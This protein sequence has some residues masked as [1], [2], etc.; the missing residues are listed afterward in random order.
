MP[1]LPT[2]IFL[3]LL[4]LTSLVAAQPRHLYLTWTQ[5]DTA[6][7]QTV[8][9]QTLGQATN[10]R[11]ELQVSSAGKVKAFPVKTA[12]FRFNGRRVHWQTFSGLTPKTSYRFRA[13]DDTYGL[14][15]WRTFRT[16][17]ADDSPIRVLTGGDMYVHPATVQLL[18]AGNS[19]HPDVALVGGDIAYAEGNP[20]RFTFWDAWLDNWSR[21]MVDKQGRMVPLILAIGNHEVRGGYGR[22]AGNAPFYFGYFPQ[23]GKPYFRRKLGSEIDLVVLDSGHATA[24]QTQAPFL[25]E[26]LKKNKTRFRLALYHVPCYPTHRPYDDPY[27]TQ[28][29][30]H[31]VPLFDKYHLNLALENHDHTFKRTHPLKGN[32][33]DP[34]GTVYLGDGC[35]GRPPRSIPGKRW[36]Q[37]KASS[38]QHVW[39]I[40][41]RKDGLH[42]QAV[43]KDAEVFD[44]T[45]IKE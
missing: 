9:F 27:S 4:A 20:N 17:P 5:E 45:V 12:V 25:E 2:R 24:H 39:L 22:P 35:W 26:F 41:N 10:P 23:G 43:D 31:W 42:C 36:Y 28:G 14:S 8:V 30:E 6:H 16:L 19:H 33:V 3:W 13:G 18:D 11:I 32:K 29:R 7:T 44:T 40:Q 34:A 1:P 38:T 15:Q 37:V 21:H